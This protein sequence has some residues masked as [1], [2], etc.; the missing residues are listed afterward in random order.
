MKKTKNQSFTLGNFLPADEKV[1]GETRL[2]LEVILRAMNDKDEK[3]L[4]SD[5]LDLWCNL[6]GLDGGYIRRKVLR[7]LK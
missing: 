5:Y 1:S 3:F 4:K 2:V 7:S 6:I